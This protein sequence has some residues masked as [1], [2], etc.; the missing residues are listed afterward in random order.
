MSQAQAW[1]FPESLQPK[2][3][4]S[5]FD[6]SRALNS[7]VLVR[8]LIPDDAFT[9]RVLGTERSGHGVV[10]RDDGLVLTIGYLVTEA[11]SIWLT[12]NRGEVVPGWPPAY[13]QATGFGQIQPLAKL[14]AAWL[15]RGSLAAVA[16]PD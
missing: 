3:E 7:I 16:P 12:T 5:A 1:A 9:A 13:H 2:A 15:G 10:I 11:N 6:L 8:A 14:R 4:S